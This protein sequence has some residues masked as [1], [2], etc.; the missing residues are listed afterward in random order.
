MK[1]RNLMILLLLT[2]FCTSTIM[3]KGQGEAGGSPAA[4]GNTAANGITALGGIGRREV[5]LSD[6]MYT[7]NGGS[8]IRLAVLAPEVQGDVPSY[9][10]MYIQGL[11]NNNINKFSKIVLIDRQNLN[12]IIAEQNLAA[13]GRY[14]DNDFVRIGNLTNTQ[15]FLFGTI[16]K[17]SGNRYSLQLSVTE[18]STGVRKANFMKDGTAAQ[19]E[20]SGA[21]INEAA[22][23]LLEQMGVQLT[24]AGKKA[25]LAGNTLTVLAETGLARGITAQAGGAEVAALF[26]FA[27]AATFDPSQLE[28]LSR[29]SNISTNISG[30]SISQRITLDIQARDKWLEVFKETF[31]FFSDH[32]P[33]EI[34]FDPN[35][36]QIG[37]TDYI[38]RT[39]NLG[40]RI[41]LNPSKAGFDALNALNEGLNKTGRRNEWGFSAWPLANITPKTAETVLF[42]GKQAFSCKVDVE[43]INEKN[44]TISKSSITLNTETICSGYNYYLEENN[45]VLI[46]C[47][48][49]GIVNFPNVKTEDL[50]DVLTISIT[51]VNGIRAQSLNASGYMKVET[52]DLETNTGGPITN[53]QF[54]PFDANQI[55]FSNQYGDTV[56]W[57]V[58]T[59]CEIRKFV[60]GGGNHY[61]DDKLSDYSPDGRQIVTVYNKI[62]KLWDAKTGREIRTFPER[63][64]DTVHFVKFINGGKQII[65]SDENTI[66]LWDAMTGM[67]VKG[68][69]YSNKIMDISYWGQ[70]LLLHNNTLQILDITSN[71]IVKTFTGSADVLCGKFVPS[72]TNNFDIITGDNKGTT[73]LW[74]AATGNVVKTFSE[75]ST[76]GNWVYSLD[77]YRNQIISQL[78]N[79]IK[80][81]DAK[82]GNLK[83]TF[84]PSPATSVCFS[85]DGRYILTGCFYSGKIRLLDAATGRL[86]KT[87]GTKEIR[88]NDLYF[89]P[90]LR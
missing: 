24:A 61:A 18:A 40:M 65:S 38:K 83:R 79:S 71:K 82:T 22:A 66:E 73:K 54:N 9:L 12:R 78:D 55:L 80:L 2:I 76:S 28:A 1:I 75:R 67:S 4:N 26:N 10:P 13:N 46:P 33:F 45:Y 20:G 29:L 16:Q 68:A 74:D 31:R 41:A 19:F 34:V 32:P 70:I 49:E 43:L 85:G 77:Y 21:V 14:S 89:L 87:I 48:V 23:E 72:N 86:L 81:W 30:G 6:L 5:A 59:G 90:P 56:L 37:E 7:G 57:D 8:N 88:R 52:G 51:A 58:I 25:L 63:H 69:L 60:R 15:Y 36:I 27:Q 3:A 84:E 44:K 64:K 11:L 62:I 39:A 53:V 17:L 50:T 42:N 35:L 47:G